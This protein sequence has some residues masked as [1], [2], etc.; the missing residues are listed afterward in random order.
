[1]PTVVH[2]SPHPDDE[3][4]GAPATL[5]A[6]RDA[7]WRVVNVACGLGRA[8]QLPRRE[9]EVREACA[10]A[11][12]EV[13]IANPPVAMSSGDDSGDARERLLHLAR[14]ELD[15]LAPELV[16]SPSPRDRHHA[17][18]LVGAAVR[19]ALSERGGEA[20]R[21]WMWG[22]W[23]PLPMPTLATAFDVARL[24][25]ILA[26]LGAYQGELERNDYRRFVRARA[27]MSS[28]LGPELV[29]GF[30]NEAPDEVR[31][32]E[33]LTEA[34]WV[35]GRWLLG[36][37]RWLDPAAAL[38]E[39]SDVAIDIWLGGS[40][41]TQGLR[42]PGAQGKAGVGPGKPGPTFD[43]EERKRLWELT[44][45][46]DEVFNQRHALFLIAEAMLAVTY[47]T[48]LDAR[49]H[50]V[51]GVIAAMGILLTIAW[52]YVSVRHGNKLKKVQGRAKAVLPDYEEVARLSLSAKRPWRSVSSQSVA[53]IG[54]PLLIGVLWILLFLPRI[55][56]P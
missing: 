5:M 2:F 29:F 21:W 32:V 50:W 28:S 24:E 39:P 23:G 12:F 48:A 42:A 17:H 56:P 3:L 25:E 36:R 49:E 45:H 34:A 7:G 47:A 19:D 51:A 11:G 9:A 35:D 54:V 16:L 46:E 22:L 18:E 41:D 15:E 44:L 4:I 53:A 38:I 10:R 37:A 6:L 30:G 8:D 20:Q 1:M 55:T 40:S 43:R 33:L 31:F 26:A 14:R 13:R 27:E 52:L